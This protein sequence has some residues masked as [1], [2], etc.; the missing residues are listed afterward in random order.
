[1]QGEDGGKVLEVFLSI[2]LMNWQLHWEYQGI[3]ELGDKC[4]DALVELAE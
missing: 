3:L 1:M 4:D 2:S